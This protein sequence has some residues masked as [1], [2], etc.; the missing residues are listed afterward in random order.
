MAVEVSPTRTHATWKPRTTQAH[1][2]FYRCKECGHV[3]ANVD[4]AHE[5]ALIDDGERSLR[6]DLPCGHETLAPTCHGAAMEPLEP[7]DWQEVDERFHFDYRFMGGYDNNCIEV[8]WT[9]KEEGCEPRWFAMKTFTGMQ[10]KYIQPKKYPPVVFAYADEDAYVYCDRSP[11]QE[12][13]FRCKTGM[14]LYCYVPSIG[15]IMHD[16]GRVTMLESTLK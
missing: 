2:P 14:E 6:M 16:L 1:Y 5:I 7:I 13:Q 11:C 12:C 9:V 8:S 10:L 3:Y 4:D 15:L